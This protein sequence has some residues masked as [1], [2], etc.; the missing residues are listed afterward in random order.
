MEQN[1]IILIVDDNENLRKTMERVLKRKGHQVFTAA[2]GQEALLVAQK[3][4]GIDIV[5]MD[6]KMPL[7]NGVETH[8]K[9][10][11]IL[12]DALVIMMTAYAVDDLIQ[13]ALSDGAYGVVHKPLDLGSFDSM[14]AVIDKAKRNLKGALVLVVDDDASLS[15]SFRRILERRG[16][17]VMIAE[18]GEQAIELAKSQSFDILFIDM[19]LPTINGLETYKSIRKI[20]PETIAIMM[21]G[22]PKDMNELVDEALVSSAYSCLHKPLDMMQI[23]SLVDQ[24]LARKTENK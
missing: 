22:F 9:L 15:S 20:R 23:F 5:F 21:T 16:M 1:G 12:P 4:Q 24:I 17:S 19:K 8:K 10:K 14:I 6:I 13:E 11:T 3:N 18:D 2:D 7:M